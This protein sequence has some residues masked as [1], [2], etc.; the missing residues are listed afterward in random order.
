MEL[1]TNESIHEHLPQGKL[2]IDNWKPIISPL[3]RQAGPIS[4]INNNF[5]QQVGEVLGIWKPRQK[6]KD[7]LIQ[8]LIDTLERNQQDGDCNLLI[9]ALKELS[10]EDYLLQKQGK[11]NNK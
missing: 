9:A 8:S 1:N 5:K 2:D 11:I 4:D 10:E 6:D 7:N 3:I